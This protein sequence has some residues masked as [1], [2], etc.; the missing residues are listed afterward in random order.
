MQK[1]FSL[2]ISYK[3]V[4]HDDGIVEDYNPILLYSAQF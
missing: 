1:N 4:A 2:Q 3:S